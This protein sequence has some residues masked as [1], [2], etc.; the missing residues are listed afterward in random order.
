MEAF[1]KIAPGPIG[2]PARTKCTVSPETAATKL[3]FRKYRFG[4]R[5]RLIHAD[6]AASFP[7]FVYRMAPETTSPGGTRDRGKPTEA[8]GICAAR[9]TIIKDEAPGG[10]RNRF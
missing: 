5:V 9:T 7:V 8:E 3:A 10:T 2:T 4:P 6:R 1:T